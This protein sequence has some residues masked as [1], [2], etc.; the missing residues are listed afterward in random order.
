MRY[1]GDKSPKIM[2]TR[3]YGYACTLISLLPLVKNSFNFEKR[4]QYDYL[5]GF[6]IINLSLYTREKEILRSYKK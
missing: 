4:L 5:I 3:V 1:L 6:S 2:F